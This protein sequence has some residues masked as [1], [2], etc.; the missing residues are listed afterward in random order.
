MTGQA[1][2]YS[3]FSLE[4]GG[5]TAEQDVQFVPLRSAAAMFPGGAL[6]AAIV[7]WRMRHHRRGHPW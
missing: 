4:F 7:M 5:L 2:R 6:V 3:A 1:Y